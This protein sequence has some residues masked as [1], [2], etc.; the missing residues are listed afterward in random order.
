MK[1]DYQHAKRLINGARSTAVEGTILAKSASQKDKDEALQLV[2]G[3]LKAKMRTK[4]CIVITIE[5]H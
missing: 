3:N 2:I 4:E 1:I 5:T